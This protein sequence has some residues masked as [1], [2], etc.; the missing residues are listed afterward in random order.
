MNVVVQSGLDVMLN[1]SS[2]T[3]TEERPAAA[4][5]V[6]RPLHVSLRRCTLT[7]ERAYTCIYTRARMHLRRGHH[8]VRQPEPKLTY[9]SYCWSMYKYSIYP[10]ARAL[11]TVPS[12]SV[13][14][15]N[16]LPATYVRKLAAARVLRA[17]AARPSS[18]ASCC[19]HRR[20][21]LCQ[22]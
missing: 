2:K 1:F 22:P 12:R 6:R 10:C 21:P 18:A 8:A 17:G 13:I 20:F 7:H 15:F 4:A 9:Y 5:C 3:S 16:L 11:C 19:M 14:G